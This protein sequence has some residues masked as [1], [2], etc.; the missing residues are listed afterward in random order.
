MSLTVITSLNLCPLCLR[1]CVL[2][3]SF[4]TLSASMGQLFLFLCFSSVFQV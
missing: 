4:Q 3:L 2:S 1:V